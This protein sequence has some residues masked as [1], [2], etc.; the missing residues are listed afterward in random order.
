MGH[1]Q[2]VI[3]IYK[4][5]FTIHWLR[6]KCSFGDS[7]SHRS[8]FKYNV[9]FQ[10]G[11]TEQRGNSARIHRELHNCRGRTALSLRLDVRE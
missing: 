4:Y 2:H 6:D 7:E 1:E 8:E 11:R 10:S 9:L 3:Y 5:N